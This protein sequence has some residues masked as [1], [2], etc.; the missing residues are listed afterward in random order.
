VSCVSHGDVTFYD[1]QML[2]SAL[3]AD[4]QRG[5]ELFDVVPEELL[6]DEV[7]ELQR[8]GQVT[9][10]IGFEYEPPIDRP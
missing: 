8:S 5:R 1:A 4:P 2:A 7:R 9:D 6:T 3:A 10:H